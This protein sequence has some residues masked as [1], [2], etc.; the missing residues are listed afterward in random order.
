MVSKPKISEVNPC[1]YSHLTEFSVLAV[2][3][4]RIRHRTQGF[5][6]QPRRYYWGTNDYPMPAHAL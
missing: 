3:E 5:S 2:I 6:T 1:L 4:E